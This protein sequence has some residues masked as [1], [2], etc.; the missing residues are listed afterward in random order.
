M[1]K[2][3]RIYNKFNGLC[4]YTGKPLDDK[5][6]VDHMIAKAF[7]NAIPRPFKMNDIENLL[8]AIRIINH[9]KRAQ[10]VK[11]F[12]H[13]ISTL[14]IRLKKLPKKTSLE[15][16]KRRIEYLN[17]VAELFGVTPDKP[18]SGNFYFETLNN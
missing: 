17:E 7:F 12:R 2:R 6:Q 5:W 11:E 15:S 8:P 14:H 1:T 3:Q 13:S 10:T 18:F 4:A 16:T 9:Y